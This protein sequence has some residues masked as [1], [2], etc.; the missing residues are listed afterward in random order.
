MQRHLKYKVA[1]SVDSRV[2]TLYCQ[3]PLKVLCETE[4]VT[5]S[6]TDK[7]GNESQKEQDREK[8]EPG[9]G[10]EK[11]VSNVC[12]GRTQSESGGAEDGDEDEEDY[13]SSAD[14]QTLVRMLEEH[15]KVRLTY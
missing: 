2:Y 5:S 4:P 13:S 1:I 11:V 10:G 8:E 6:S 15:E 12:F 14:S 3:Q 9:N 7:G